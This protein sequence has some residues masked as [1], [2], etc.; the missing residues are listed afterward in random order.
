MN[1]NSSSRLPRSLA[2]LAAVVALVGA[3][4]GGSDEADQSSDPTEVVDADSASLSQT[5]PIE[6]DGEP[7]APYG[8]TPEDP[9]IGTASPVITGQAF[10][11]SPVTIGEE[12]ENPTFVVFLAH[13]CPACNEELPELVELAESDS[14]PE[15]LD[16]LAVATATTDERDNFPPSEWLDDAGWPF[17]VMAD[18]VEAEAFVAMGGTSFPYGVVLDADGTVLA[19]TVG[20]RPGADT[21]AFL[22]DALATA[23]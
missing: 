13:W 12:T 6:V 23:G 3:A 9:S 8:E 10:D 11:G 2:A 22:E 14:Y 18:S 16:V 5:A 4:C 20:V 17:P 19:R 21:V 15:G 7:L 1:T